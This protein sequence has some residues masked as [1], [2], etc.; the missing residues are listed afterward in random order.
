M[1]VNGGHAG[2]KKA[3]IE[4]QNLYTNIARRGPPQTPGSLFGVYA[5][6]FSVPSFPLKTS[7]LVYTKPCFL[8][9]EAL[10]FSERKTPLVYTFFP[11]TN[12]YHSTENHYITSHYFQ[13]LI[14]SD[15]M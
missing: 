9:V 3:P 1:A 14:M 6:S 7:F 15:V 2:T 12:K 4:A 13:E 10:E 11:P 8:P 5:I